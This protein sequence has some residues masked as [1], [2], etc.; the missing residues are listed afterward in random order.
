MELTING[1]IIEYSK[2][3]GNLAIE[4]L[5]Q[6]ELKSKKIMDFF[7]LENVGD[8]KVKIWSDYNKFKEFTLPFLKENKEEND[9]N[10]ITAHTN[11]GNINILPA[12]FVEKIWK[13]S[14]DDEELSI[15]ACHEFVHIC[16]Q[17]CLGKMGDQNSWFWEALATNLGNPEKFKLIKNE[18]ESVNW[19]EI[20]CIKDLAGK[21]YKYVYCIGKYML[22]SFSHEQILDYVKK[23]DKLEKDAEKILKNVK[24]YSEDVAQ[25]LG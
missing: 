6:L 1:I 25:N 20:N 15:D 3:D 13:R 2:Q 22:S 23:P 17:R 4:I 19:K 7:E 5:K 24:K 9:L 8:F 10:W 14:V 18:Y 11:D 16:Q 12:R 21:K